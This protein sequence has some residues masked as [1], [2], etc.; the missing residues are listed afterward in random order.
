MEMNMLNIVL[1]GPPGAGKGTQAKM[2]V[3]ILQTEQP[4]NADQLLSSM[5][6]HCKRW[7][8]VYGY[9]ARLLYPELTSVWDKHGY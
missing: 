8:Q 7:D 4:D 2:I 5:V 6:N 3:S 9:D 1:L